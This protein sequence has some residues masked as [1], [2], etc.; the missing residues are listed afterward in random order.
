VGYLSIKPETLRGG[1]PKPQ[2]RNSK[3]EIRNNFKWSKTKRL[4]NAECQGTRDFPLDTR[5]STLADF[6]FC[7][8]GR[9]K[10]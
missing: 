3:S 2:F 8:A 7:I 4:S 6:G 9:D 10:L 5:P 1:E